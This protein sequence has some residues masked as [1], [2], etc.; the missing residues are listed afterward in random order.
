MDREYFQIDE[1]AMKVGLTKRT[2]RYYEDIELINPIRTDSGY[3]LYTDADIETIERI[4]EI[5]NDLGF[6]LGDVKAVLEL[7]NDLKRIFSGQ[8]KD[9][10]LI[11]D[12]IAALK[13]HMNA[14][15]KK[16]QS[17]KQ[18]KLKCAEALKRLTEL[19]DQT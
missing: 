14:V 13:K 18:V 19:N 17:I 16:E 12:S 9:K 11:R 3:R 6:C 5:K 1:V 4:K 8:V 10:L 7:E 2:L 15:E